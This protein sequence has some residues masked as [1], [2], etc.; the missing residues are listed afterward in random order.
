MAPSIR[1]RVQILEKGTPPS[2]AAARSTK[3][4]TDRTRGE[5]KIETDNLGGVYIHG[6]DKDGSFTFCFPASAVVMGLFMSV[7]FIE[8]FEVTRF[9]MLSS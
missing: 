7:S 6:G 2:T 9:S 5:L 4:P 8:N 1:R 3:T